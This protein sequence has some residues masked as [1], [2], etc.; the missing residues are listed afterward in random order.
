[1]LEG[2]G[3][4]ECTAASCCTV[5]GDMSTGHVGPPLPCNYVK[6]VDVEEMNYYSSNGE[7]E[8]RASHTRTLALPHTLY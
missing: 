6:L 2:Y 8:V 4:T 3:Q 7:G 1:M 5:A